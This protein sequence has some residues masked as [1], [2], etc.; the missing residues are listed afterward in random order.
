MVAKF[1]RAFYSKQKS[2][3]FNRVATINHPLRSHHLVTLDN[4]SDNKF[5]KRLEQ[6][7][8]SPESKEQK[9]RKLVR[10]IAKKISDP[11]YRAYQITYR[12]RQ[13]HIFKSYSK[14]IDLAFISFLR[15]NFTCCY[16]TLIQVTQEVLR[17]WLVDLNEGDNLQILL[18]KIKEKI[19]FTKE[20]LSEREKEKIMRGNDNKEITITKDGE[21][22]NQLKYITTLY[23]YFALMVKNI[24]QNN[25]LT[26]EVLSNQHVNTHLGN[27]PDYFCNP[28]NAL[29]LIIFLDVIAELYLWKN[30][31]D[32]LMLTSNLDT[33]FND[34]LFKKYQRFYQNHC[35]YNS[36]SKSAEDLLL[37]RFY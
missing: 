19:L 9:N 33:K 27:K 37:E 20:E 7:T 30:H 6:I 12:Y 25:Q 22:L 17:K 8:N 14:V 18:D 13:L 10:T 26:H 32:Y 5:L 1:I 4:F 31:H 29:A 34:K 35:K 36:S 21:C 24:F 16:L 2:N 23:K 15:G 3:K 28:S 11:K